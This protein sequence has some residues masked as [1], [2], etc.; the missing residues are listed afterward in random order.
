MNTYGIKN[1]LRVTIG[2]DEENKTFL[3]ILDKKFLMNNITIIGIGLIGSS[4][5]RA[6]RHNY[7]KVLINFIDVSEDNLKKVKVYLWQIVTIL[8]LTRTLRNQNLFLFV[9]Q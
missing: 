2:T 1:S 7:S 3:D 5:A 4:L 6:I 9:H 8:K